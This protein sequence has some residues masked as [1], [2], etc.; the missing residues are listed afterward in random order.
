LETSS[1]VRTSGDLPAAMES[2]VNRTLRPV[3]ELFGSVYATSGFLPHSA[4]A[5]GL[6]A[7][8]RESEL[9]AMISL[10]PSG[11]LGQPRHSA[12][13]RKVAMPIQV[14]ASRFAPGISTTVLLSDSLMS[15]SQ[16]SAT[17]VTSV[18]LERA[19]LMGTP[20]RT[21]LNSSCLITPEFTS[22]HWTSIR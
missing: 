18:G 15:Y 6:L 10:Y 22:C 21:R 20:V 12:M 16:C 2:K 11:R 3:E 8:P 4:W 9:R 19:R 13:S 17:G 7:Q 14:R 1:A 5:Q